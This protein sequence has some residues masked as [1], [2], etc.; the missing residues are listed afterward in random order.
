MTAYLIRDHEL[1]PDDALRPEAE[2]WHGAAVD[3]L[4][5]LLDLLPV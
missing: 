1:H 3:D 4:R 5:E 2:E